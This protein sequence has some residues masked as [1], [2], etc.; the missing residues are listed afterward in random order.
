LET[1]DK[2][3][4][5]QQATESL[6]Q[7][8]ANAAKVKPL[9]NIH[10]D[11]L[12]L[13]FRQPIVINAYKEMGLNDIVLL[14]PSIGDIV[15]VSEPLFYSTLS[16]FTT[17]PTANRLLLWN[18][19]IDWN[20]LTDYG[21]FVM[22]FNRINPEISKLIFQDV[23]FTR[24]KRLKKNDDILFYNEEQNIVIDENIYNIISLYFRTM[25]NAF[26]KTEKTV[27]AVAKEWIIE[28]ELMNAAIKKDEDKSS[29][30][31]LISTC[32]NHPGFK[33]KSSELINVGIFE[34]MDSVKRLQIY[35]SATAVMKGMYGGFV[36]AKKIDKEAYNFMKES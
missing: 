32:V 3:E 16:V 8:S 23:D 34:F 35:E 24:F 28:E 31:S 30:F 4:V 19:G 1:L 17:N 7:K 9:P 2:K 25:F 22:F 5:F 27:D 12:K 20:D 29:L 18:E 33:Y 10:I 11:K 26:P 6:M 14:Q 21:L 15:K 36:D 13:Y